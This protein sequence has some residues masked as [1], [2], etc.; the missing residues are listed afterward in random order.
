MQLNRVIQAQKDFFQT[1]ETKRIE[2]RKNQLYKLAEAIEEYKPEIYRALREDLNK[3][4]YETCLMELGPVINEI[5]TAVKHLDKWIR[6]NKKKTTTSVWG[7]RTF[8]IFEPYGTT[9]ILSPWNYPFQLALA[10]V[11]G[12]MAAGNCIVLKTSKSSSHTSDVIARMIRTN[13]E[14]H[15]FYVVEEGTSYDAILQEKYD[16]IFFTGGPRVGRIVMRQASETLTPATLELGGKSPCIVEKTADLKDAA[17]KII[18]GK[19]VNAGQTCVAPDF[20][21]VEEEIKEDLIEEMEEQIATLCG[22]ATA[23][24]DY[25]KIV[26]LHHFMR[27]KRLMEKEAEVIG[28]Q[29]DEEK[30][31]IAPAILP[32]ATFLSESMKEEIFGPILPV[33]G[34]SQ[35]EVALDK[36][37]SRP[38]PLACYI[39]TK[40]MGF[41]EKIV[42]EF[43]YGGGCINDCIMHVASDNLPFGGVGNSGMGKYHGYYS[44]QTFSHEKAILESRKLLADR[45][46][47]PPFTQEKLASLRKLLKL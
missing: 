17:K 16:Y 41:A 22:N 23:N 10:P 4:E 24:P 6:P 36:L 29:M 5:R 31:I 44:F 27:L 25:P 46:R 39:F 32:R 30:R 20:V 45:F 21:L 26:N 12:A 47:F 14:P 13:F 34:Y 28:G 9:L 38:K 33:I 11:V 35:I 43:S 19:I 8:T 7:S 15:Y 18:W 3:S 42:T 37:K 2:F 40:D 1:N